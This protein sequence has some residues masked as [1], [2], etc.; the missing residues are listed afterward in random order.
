MQ[1][2]TFIASAGL[3]STLV[4]LLFGHYFSSFRWWQE[5]R[6]RKIE[7]LYVLLRNHLI[8]VDNYYLRQTLLL[9]MPETHPKAEEAAKKMEDYLDALAED[10]KKASL[11]PLLVNAYF[12]TL[13]PH[14]DKVAAGAKR[15]SKANQPATNLI[16]QMGKGAMFTKEH[17]DNV[18][19][20]AASDITSRRMEFINE[21]EEMDKYVIALTRE[22]SL[23]K[24]LLFKYIQVIYYR[25]LRIFKKPVKQTI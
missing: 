18:A 7:E 22:I 20:Q 2:L 11:I 15:V 10:E 12:P 17:K 1:F 6:L 25:C 19:M 24:P 3:V 13:F 9:Q 5:Y 23:E 8:A 16:Y 21:V 14:W 4:S